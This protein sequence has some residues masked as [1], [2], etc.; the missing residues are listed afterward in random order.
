MMVRKLVFVRKNKHARSTPQMIHFFP[1][2]RL[3]SF[4]VKSVTCL[5]D[6]GTLLAPGFWCFTKANIIPPTS[7]ARFPIHIPNCNSMKID[8]DTVHSI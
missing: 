2:T 1:S 7:D 6:E 3:L 8:L 4:D 5:K